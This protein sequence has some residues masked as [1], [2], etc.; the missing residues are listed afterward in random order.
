L[1]LCFP[2]PSGDSSDGGD[3][4]DGSCK[5]MKELESVKDDVK[6]LRQD[7]AKKEDDFRH[8]ESEALQVNSWA[9]G[10]RWP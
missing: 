6:H 7:K 3:A 5:H 8:L 2:G 4:C 9:Y 1:N 10:K